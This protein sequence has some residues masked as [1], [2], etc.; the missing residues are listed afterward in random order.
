MRAEF[1]LV[2]NQEALYNYIIKNHHKQEEKVIHDRMGVLKVWNRG[3]T[4][5]TAAERLS[6]TLLNRSVLTVRTGFEQAT[7]KWPRNLRKDV[8]G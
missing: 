3:G 1:Q 5:N 2:Y 6:G 4:L 7:A 8:S